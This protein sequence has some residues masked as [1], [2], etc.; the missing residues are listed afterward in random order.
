[1][2]GKLSIGDVLP[3]VPPLL[4]DAAPLL[5]EDSIPLYFQYGTEIIPKQAF[6]EVDLKNVVVEDIKIEKEETGLLII[7]SESGKKITLPMA[8]LVG[9]KSK[10]G[11]SFDGV[12]VSNVPAKLP[13]KAIVN[14]KSAFVGSYMSWGNEEIVNY[15]ENTFKNTSAI[16]TSLFLRANQN[17]GKVKLTEAA[18]LKRFLKEEVSFTETEMLVIW[19]EVI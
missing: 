3:S 7:V 11:V 16:D 8:G 15:F 5:V 19:I 12:A 14:V 9:L 4:K 6:T 17:I 1:M 13:L 2:Q 18:V 10:K